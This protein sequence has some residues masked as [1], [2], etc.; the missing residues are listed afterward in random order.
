MKTQRTEIISSLGELGKYA[1]Y[2][3]EIEVAA[4]VYYAMMVSMET[5]KYFHT[6][7]A[8]PLTHRF[9]SMNLVIN[10]HWD[11]PVIVVSNDKECVLILYVGDTSVMAAVEEELKKIE[12]GLLFEWI[13]KISGILCK[14][15]A[16]VPKAMKFFGRPGA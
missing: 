8:T 12:R 10:G 7:H 14:I 6:S 15:Y 16:I 13:E 9:Y 11:N 5:Y 3:D 4:P 2:Y 1:F